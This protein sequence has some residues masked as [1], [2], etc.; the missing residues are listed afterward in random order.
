[1]CQQNPASIAIASCSAER[2]MS[3]VRI[4]KNR[5]LSTMLDDWFSSL[6]V[7]ASERDILNDISTDEITDR[8]A[9]C[10]QPLQK[11]AFMPLEFRSLFT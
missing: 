8:L 7:M 2:A 9:R 11:A 5:L 6:M 1:M 3:R 4:V 10:S